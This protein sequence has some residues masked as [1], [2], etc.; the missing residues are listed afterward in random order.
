M[1][2]I[3]YLP[4]PLSSISR[5]RRFSQPGGQAQHRFQSLSVAANSPKGAPL[6][7]PLHEIKP[8]CG[9]C[10]SCQ[11]LVY[12]FNFLSSLWAVLSTLSQQHIFSC[13][14]IYVEWVMTSGRCMEY[15]TVVTSS[16]DHLVG[17]NSIIVVKGLAPR[18]RKK[19]RRKLET[20]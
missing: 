2:S 3:F 12:C 19:Q 1:A 10:L 13:C 15:K 8:M 5:C 7:R 14:Q 17:I 6:T 18:K 9:S 4:K 20:S 11:P 16:K